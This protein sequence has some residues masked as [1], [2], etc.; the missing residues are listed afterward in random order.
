MLNKNIKENR[1][2]DHD[3]GSECEK[4]E[5]FELKMKSPLASGG[6][7][8]PKS[9]D[10]LLKK[11]RIR[12]RI[13]LPLGTYLRKISEFI[14]SKKEYEEVFLEILGDATD[15]YNEALFKGRH[16]KARMVRF[17]L[18]CSFGHA[19]WTLCIQKLLPKWL[20]RKLIG[21]GD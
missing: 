1:A 2:V 5:T 11:C 16:W 15:E 20:M 21:S 10:R 9:L 3:E 18:Y 6:H 13:T 12:K 4:N 19:F 8:P 7:P 17:Q 14:F